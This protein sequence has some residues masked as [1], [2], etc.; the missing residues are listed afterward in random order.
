MTVMLELSAEK[1]LILPS[2]EEAI[3]RTKCMS[4]RGLLSV[5]V[6]GGEATLGTANLCV[7]HEQDSLKTFG[8]R[9]LV[10]HCRL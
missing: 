9:S 7:L 5:S 8:Y 6:K 1:W 10:R 2:L 4:E 3:A